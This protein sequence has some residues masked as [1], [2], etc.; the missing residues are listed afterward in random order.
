MQ[1]RVDLFAIF[2][3]L[4]IV[5]AIFLCVFFF[6]KENRKAQSNVFHGLMLLSIALCNL[7]IVLMYTGYIKDCLWLVDFSEPLAFVI[8]PAFYLMVLSLIHGEVR[9]RN[10]WHFA[11]AILYLFLVIP[12]FLQPDV[13]KYNSW[14]GSYHP[15]LP[16][17]ECDFE[18]RDPRIFW[19]T[20]N[21]TDLTLISLFLY[22]GLG[23]YEVIKAFRIRKESFLSPS[24]SVLKKL[25]AGA[26]QVFIATTLLFVIKIF[27]ESDTGDHF[28]S[29][30][31]S[32]VI[33]LTS[34]RVINQSGFFKPAS[35]AEP[36]RYK[37]SN[38]N[39]QVRDGLLA[40]LKGVMEGEKPFLQPGFSL[41][42]LSEKLNTTVHTLS[43][44]INEGLGKSFF[45]MTAEYRV[46]EAKKLL[47]EK[48]N[49]KVEEIAEQVGYNSKSSFNIAFKKITG[50]TPSEFRQQDQATS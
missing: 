31:L 10:Y 32:I 25:R 26:T 21:H 30:Y 5:Q 18:G 15:E 41:P 19:I 34:F 13:V 17:M 49:I 12:F 46:T 45:E 24:N 4:G 1:Y 28:F 47:L 2:I 36:Q 8:G 27:Y 29:V 40:R 6:S 14:I 42:E 38:V 50:K 44:V 48:R 7:E 33:Y 37:D 39:V 35:L 9:K 3:F 11:F 16:F 22:L 20:D 23:L 43:Q